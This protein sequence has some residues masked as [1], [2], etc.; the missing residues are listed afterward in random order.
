[1]THCVN[2]TLP[3]ELK[4]D[5]VFYTGAS[6]CGNCKIYPTKGEADKRP[7]C[8]DKYKCLWVLG[9]GDEEDRPDKSLMLFDRS[10]DVENAIEAKPL[11][12]GREETQE[13][14]DVI[15]RMAIST[16]KTVLVFNLYERRI[17]SVVGLPVK[18]K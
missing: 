3:G 14:K 15:D 8:C 17:V 11:A 1:M 18:D 2:L 7:E 13:A 16:N 6:D 5:S 9:H 12:S 10:R 4:K